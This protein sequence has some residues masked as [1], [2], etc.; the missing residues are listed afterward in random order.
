MS[1]ITVSFRLA[2]CCRCLNFSQSL[3]TNGARKLAARTTYARYR[4]NL[5]AP[6]V[7][8]QNTDFHRISQQLRRTLHRLQGNDRRAAK[9]K[10][11]ASAA[12]RRRVGPLLMICYS[13]C[14]VLRPATPPSAELRANHYVRESLAARR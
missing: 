8:V 14:F 5:N 3:L 1:Q 7:K 4:N 11:T 6:A 10:F 13:P 12:D 2:L 9:S